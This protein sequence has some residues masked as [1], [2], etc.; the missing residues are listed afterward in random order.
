MPLIL[1]RDLPVIQTLRNENICVTNGTGDVNNEARPLKVA[2]LN[3]MPD[4]RAD[5]AQ[6]LRALSGTP[7]PVE[8][9][10]LY[11]QSHVSKNTPTEY[12][13]TFYKTF[14]EVKCKKYDGL[15]VTG[16]ALERIAFRDVDYWDELGT[17]MDWS[18]TNVTSTMH[19]CWG[20]LAG[21]YHHHGVPKHL[22]PQKKFGVFPHTIV[23]A[24][25]KMKIFRGFGE[26][27]Y[28]P[29]SIHAEAKTEDILR[30]PQLI[31][32]SASEEAGAYIVLATEGRQLFVTRHPEYGRDVLKR[33]YERDLAK[34]LNIAV[35]KNY[36]PDDCAANTPVMHW[37]GHSRQLFGNWL[38]YYVCGEAD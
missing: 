8:V 6:F 16:A 19:I 33:E 21:L 17:F 22:L 20:A 32:L 10:F 35:P 2:I 26:T 37:R 15:I 11:A 18:L 27:F 5:E 3:L 29:H 25:Q 23:E 24:Y 4:K 13:E 12:L 1:P 34:G 14:D 36:F 28:A 30:V 38:Q 31:L 9:E 7:L